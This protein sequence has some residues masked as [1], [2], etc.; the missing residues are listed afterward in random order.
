[1]PLAR[2]AA[3]AAGVFGFKPDLGCLDVDQSLGVAL[4]AQCLDV[5]V[6]NVLFAQ[7]GLQLGVQGH[8][9]MPRLDF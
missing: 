9:W 3:V 4:E 2:N 6:F 5:G 1:M 7:D 8:D